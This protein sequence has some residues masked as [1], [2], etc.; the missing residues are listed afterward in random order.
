MYQPN[1][2]QLWHHKSHGDMGFHW[3][4]VQLPSS[5]FTPTLQFSWVVEVEKQAQL[6]KTPVR[7]LNIKTKE[8]KDKSK[9]TKTS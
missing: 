1:A 3:Y 7:I 2:N 4:L 9:E 5:T 8:V 6:H